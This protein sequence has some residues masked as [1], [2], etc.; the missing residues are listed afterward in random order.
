VNR[1]VTYRESHERKHSLESYNQTGL[2]KDQQAV[3]E[4]IKDRFNG[5]IKPLKAT[6]FGEISA[7]L[8]TFF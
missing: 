4:L 6:K 1:D 3:E 8:K 5:S 2:R 7:V